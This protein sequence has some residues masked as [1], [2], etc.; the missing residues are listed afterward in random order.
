MGI[1]IYPPT[2]DWSYMKQRPQHLMEQFSRRGYDV[3]Y[4]NKH[5]GPGPV[6]E[7][8]ER[9]LFLVRHP[10][11]FLKHLYPRIGS[12]RKK[13]YWTS[14]SKK[15]PHGRDVFRADVTIYDCVDDFPDWEPY[16]TEYAPLADAIVCTADPL[17]RKISGSLP[18]KPVYLVPNGCDWNHFS[19][20]LAEKKHTLEN[21]PPASGPKIGYIGAWAP[22]VD[23][24]WIRKAAEDIPGAQILIVGPR[25]REDC[26]P[27]GPNVHFLGYRDYETLPDILAYLDVCIIPFRK[28]RI[29]ESTNP[30]KVYEYLAAGKPV[31]SSDLPEVN[32]LRPYVHLASS[33]EQFV[34]QILECAA[35]PSGAR[36]RSL[37]AKAH[38][39]ERRFQEVDRIIRERFPEF[40]FDKQNAIRM[41]QF[42]NWSSQSVPLSG[43][44]VHPY[45]ASR[46]LYGGGLFVGGPVHPGHAAG[47]ECLL[48][49]QIPPEF[50]PSGACYLEFEMPLSGELHLEV[51]AI[52]GDWSASEVTYDNQ[53]RHGTAVRFS[54]L[55]GVSET[56]SID[57]SPL[58]NAFWTETGRLPSLHLRSEGGTLIRLSN[59]RLTVF[60]QNN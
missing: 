53:P 35:S 57:I 12:G 14:W 37:A 56:L 48:R 18:G 10:A 29:T 15:I 1:V 55:P 5:S 27:L 25:L 22:W 2:I 45:Y 9:R 3:L 8:L 34:R 39:W 28:S 19:K 49:A 6:V 31:V 30:V 32:K 46:N 43:C 33:P 50:S 38:S 26:G 23:E 40:Y 20:A 60:I 4:F 16:E 36:Q 7:M 42:L 47:Y 44:S 52:A 11:F 21:L 51:S 13:L 58:V 54:I 59:P 41:E 17:Y 24:G